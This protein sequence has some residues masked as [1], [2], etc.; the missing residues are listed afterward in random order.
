M[1][2]SWNGRSP[3]ACS[4]ILAQLELYAHAQVA[5]EAIA[6]RYIHMHSIIIAIAHAHAHAQCVDKERSISA[7]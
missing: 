5:I 2:S 6:H 4:A 1:A 3:G 7:G